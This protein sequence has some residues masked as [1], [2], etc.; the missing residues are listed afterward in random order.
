M[1]AVIAMADVMGAQ[2][3]GLLT[4]PVLTLD[5]LWELQQLKAEIGHTSCCLIHQCSEYIC[6]LYRISKAI[7]PIFGRYS[8][9][10][11]DHR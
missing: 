9:D 8:H 2:P 1:I 3:N 5:V 11:L 6:F 4:S 7:D 10:Q